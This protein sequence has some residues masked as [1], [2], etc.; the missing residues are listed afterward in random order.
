MLIK[1]YQKET[2]F[3]VKEHENIPIRSILGFNR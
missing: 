1:Y 2:N 3:I